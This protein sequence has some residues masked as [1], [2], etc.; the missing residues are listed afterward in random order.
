S[1]KQN[2]MK[3]LLICMFIICTGT[4]LLAQTPDQTI[5][6][7]ILDN[8]TRV[9]LPAA[10]IELH[11]ADTICRSL[12]DVNGRFRFNHVPVGRATLVIVFTGYETK[13]I[14]NIL[15]NSG[16]EVVLNIELVESVETLNSVVI[17]SN[18]QGEVLNEMSLS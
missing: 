11:Y 13:T 6:G 3:S 1:I 4:D 16:K 5:R 15:V 12:S 14:P 17:E 2:T 9:T 18:E 8:D 7:T 10:K